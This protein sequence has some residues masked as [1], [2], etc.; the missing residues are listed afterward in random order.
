MQEVEYLAKVGRIDNGWIVVVGSS[1][2]YCK[3][4]EEIGPSI[5]AKYSAHKILHGK[6]DDDPQQLELDLNQ[7][8]PRYY[9]KKGENT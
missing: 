7:T 1:V 6:K 4:A 2:M 9:T 8:L 3:N 5:I